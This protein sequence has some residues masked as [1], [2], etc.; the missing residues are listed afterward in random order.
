[1]WEPGDCV[2]VATLQ[3]L[4]GRPPF[5]CTVVEK[6]L[7]AYGATQARVTQTPGLMLPLK[8]AGS[9]SGNF[10]HLNRLNTVDYSVIFVPECA[11]VGEV[12]RAS[13]EDPEF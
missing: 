3:Q 2:G 1:M 13:R 9:V 10:C 5:E 7:G 8:K 11:H 6:P 12:L 4:H